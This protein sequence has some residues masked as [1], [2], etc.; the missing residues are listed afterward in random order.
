MKIQILLF[1]KRLPPA[2]RLAFFIFTASFVCFY[3]GVSHSCFSF[4]FNPTSRWQHHASAK[5]LDSLL[6]LATTPLRHSPHN[7]ASGCSEHFLGGLT[8]E[9]GRISCPALQEIGYQQK[10]RN[11]P[12]KRRLLTCLMSL[13]SITSPPN[14][15]FNLLIGLDKS[16]GQPFP[17]VLFAGSFRLHKITTDPHF[18][19]HVNTEC[20]DY[21]C[22]KFKIFVS[23]PN[24]DRYK[25]KLQHT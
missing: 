14:T 21:K 1:H 10:Q 9:M 2:G 19:P 24:I 13:N 7:H 23:E 25:Y 5:H 17:K 20:L 15:K 22:S 11:I 18:L 3:S 6:S 12:E 8:S 4:H 16:L